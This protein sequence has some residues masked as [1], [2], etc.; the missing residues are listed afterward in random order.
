MVKIIKPSLQRSLLREMSNRPNTLYALF[1]LFS[2]IFVDSGENDGVVSS[3]ACFLVSKKIS[4]ISST[5]AS[6]RLSA[7]TNRC[8]SAFKSM[9]KLDVKVLR[10]SMSRLDWS[11]QRSKPCHS[12][13]YRQGLSLR[14]TRAPG[15]LLHDGQ[16]LHALGRESWNDLDWDIL[17]DV[18]VKSA[19]CPGLH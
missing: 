3:S 14:C 6:T 1:F 8:D 17:W 19:R 2:I 12:P 9:Q 16:D 4:L 10:I 7:T 13:I 5:C 18:V 15:E 11:S